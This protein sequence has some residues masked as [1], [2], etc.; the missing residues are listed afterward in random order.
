M[1]SVETQP[2]SLIPGHPTDRGAGQAKPQGRR[3]SHVQPPDCPGP[4][5]RLRNPLLCPGTA[6][7]PGSR[8]GSPAAAGYRIGIQ[9]GRLLPPPATARPARAPAD[10]LRRGRAVTGLFR[11]HNGCRPRRHLPADPGRQAAGAGGAHRS[12]R[13]GRRTGPAGAAIRG[14]AARSGHFFGH[15]ERRRAPGRRIACFPELRSRQGPPS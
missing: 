13:P 11:T 7:A 14:S 9:S 6:P 8:F 3:P 5:R 10:L 1:P 12:A 4:R 2:V 15:P